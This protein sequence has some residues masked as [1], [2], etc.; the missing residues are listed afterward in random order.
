MNMSL[1]FILVDGVEAMIPRSSIISMYIYFIY[2][3]KRNVY[4][5]VTI[6]IR[7]II[8]IIAQQIMTKVREILIMAA[9]AE[10]KIVVLIMV[11]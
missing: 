11:I 7:Q 10:V 3:S 6:T 4:F 9:V 5:I 2:I 8:I 1:R